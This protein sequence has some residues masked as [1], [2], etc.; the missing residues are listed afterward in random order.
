MHLFTSC[1]CDDI[2][3][4]LFRIQ[5]CCGVTMAYLR[6]SLKSITLSVRINKYK[7]IVGHYRPACNDFIKL[8]VHDHNIY[9]RIP[10]NELLPY[11]PGIEVNTDI[12]LNHT[13][14]LTLPKLPAEIVHMIQSYNK[15]VL[16][17]VRCCDSA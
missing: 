12:V 13:C 5:F 9:I 16:Q 6:A 1:K 2:H 17:C 4:L 15:P 8:D 10:V 3:T 11:P 7:H 14:E